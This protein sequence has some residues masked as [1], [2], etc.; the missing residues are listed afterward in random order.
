MLSILEYRRRPHPD[1]AYYGLPCIAHAVRVP[2]L[3]ATNLF[4]KHGET[5]LPV[6]I[7]ADLPT[8][9]RVALNQP[10][11]IGVTLQYQY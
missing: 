5:D 1:H 6:A 7:S 3:Y 8:T 4:D 2:L 9:R 10:R 11:T